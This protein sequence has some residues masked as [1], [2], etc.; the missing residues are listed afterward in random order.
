M[1]TKTD[2]QSESSSR[3]PLCVPER[4]HSPSPGK[5]NMYSYY[6][7]SSSSFGGTPYRVGYPDNYGSDSWRPERSY[8]DRAPPPEHFGPPYLRNT[9]TENWNRPVSYSASF[10]WPD[11]RDSRSSMH[12]DLWPRVHRD[13]MAQR[14]FE[15]SENWKQSH[16]QTADFSGGGTHFH[17][18]FA[19]PS[20][21]NM[22]PP[23]HYRPSSPSLDYKDRYP[24]MNPRSDSYR[25]QYEDDRGPW[26]LHSTEPYRNRYDG[27]VG[28]VRTRHISHSM[29]PPSPEV[30]RE[31]RYDSHER[32]ASASSRAGLLASPHPQIPTQDESRSPRSLP[33]FHPSP[34]RESFEFGLPPTS[35]GASPVSR[36]VSRSSS[37]S[38]HS[39]RQPLR[40]VAKND[41]PTSRS[42]YAD[43]L[44]STPHEDTDIPG[45]IITAPIPIDTEQETDL[46]GTPPGLRIGLPSVEDMNNRETGTL[47]V[48]VDSGQSEFFAEGSP[49]IEAVSSNSKKGGMAIHEYNLTAETSDTP[50]DGSDMEMSL[51]PSPVVE[52]RLATTVKADAALKRF[53]QP[54][55]TF[56]RQDYCPRS[57]NFDPRLS[58]TDHSD[59]EMSPP[60]SPSRSGTKNA[61]EVPTSPERLNSP[62]QQPTSQVDGIPSAIILE[63]T[64]SAEEPHAG[65]RDIS[66]S[67]LLVEEEVVSHQDGFGTDDSDMDMSP[68]A[69][70]VPFA[71]DEKELT[72]AENGLARIL[73]IGA[74]S[75]L[76]PIRSPYHASGREPLDM[77]MADES[78]SSIRLSNA[79][80]AETELI[81][82]LAATVEHPL[83]TVSP[84]QSLQTCAP[85]PRSADTSAFPRAGH[86]S[87]QIDRASNH[88]M[89]GDSATIGHD[90]HD[91]G[92]SG[93][94]VDSVNNRP[95]NTMTTSKVRDK[96]PLSEPLRLVVMTRLRYDRQTKEERVNPVLFANLAIAEPPSL[97]S[98]LSADAVVNG[99]FGSERSPFRV[100]TLDRAKPTLQIRFAQRKA[101]LAEKIQ[102]LR[103]EYLA[104][105][106]RW[107]H[108]CS[109]LD[110]VAKAHALEEAAATAGRTTRRSAALGDAVRSDLEME[111]II[112]SLGNE[113]LTD[114]NHLA[115]RNAA[116]IPDMVSLTNGP[117]EFMFDDT[118]NLVDDPISFYAPRTGT[119]DWTEEEKAVYLERFAVYPKQFGIIAELLPNKSA[120]QC[121][122][123]Y[124]LHKKTDIDFRK[125][126][127]LYATGKRMR[128][129]RKTAKKKGNA[130][131]TDIRKHDAEVSRD[132]TS[133]GTSTRRKRGV[134]TTSTEPRRS[135]TSRRSTTRLET[136]PITTPTP[137]PEPESRRRRRAPKL[138]ARAIAAMEQEGDDEPTDDTPKP[139]KRGR[140]SRKVIKSAETVTSPI[141]M[142]ECIAVF[143][144]TKF[145]DQTE[146]SSRKKSATGNVNWSEEDKELFL[147]L[148][149]QHG[150]DF[151]RIAASMPN[152][153]TIQVSIF[154]KANLEEMDLAKVA[155]SAPKRSPTPETAQDIWKET[156]LPGSGVITPRTKSSTPPDGAPVPVPGLG[157]ET[158]LRSN[159]RSSRSRR[160][161][162]Q[163]LYTSS[164]R[165]QRQTSVT[166]EPSTSTISS[167]GGIQFRQTSVEAMRAQY[168]TSQDLPSRL[169]SQ[170]Q[171]RSS[172]FM[173]TLLPQINSSASSMGDVP[174]SSVF[175]PPSTMPATLTTTFPSTFAYSN[176]SPSHFAGDHRPPQRLTTIQR[177]AS[178]SG[179]APS[180]TMTFD[181]S[182]FTQ[183]PW[184]HTTHL[185]GQ[186]T[187][188]TPGL[189]TT[190]QTTEDLRAYLEHRTRLAGQL[191][192]DFIDF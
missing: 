94:E 62:Q 72:P 112:A 123:Y 177:G 57:D 167:T 21:R 173:G 42:V 91:V 100:D 156:N 153:T 56:P 82:D 54:P 92:P 18:R 29:Q 166:P 165:E 133:K 34:L 155:A 90:Q 119:D 158:H 106:E 63:K 157:V 68:P 84:P 20:V 65:H 11:S 138:T 49:H 152:K 10:A 71:L 33:Y 31:R 9:Q 110:E 22:N 122:T 89:G 93:A 24:Y 144:E 52:S 39:H 98:S 46:A 74:S 69:S 146:L 12:D 76:S 178:P 61:S 192:S 176:L 1:F 163:E 130:L 2:Y 128:G 37:R 140:R 35:R 118:N 148:L 88:S 4:R 26:N 19:E 132:S 136:S 43:S 125:V 8:H 184:S 187:D 83:Q 55:F 86:D 169:Y 40:D 108:H 120:A 191:P 149:A 77:V 45:L 96:H 3:P 117:V 16:G 60:P 36:I 64:G 80:P 104:L 189:P 180:S 107:M 113:E 79:L 121:V 174:G 103:E 151:K 124:Y 116:K 5:S 99:V 171:P 13:T 70:P 129:N 139:A 147:K 105:H 38:S 142:D 175:T 95:P 78:T 134:Q 126:V 131:L 14:M 17:D 143:N 127:S 181:A 145:I 159:E 25:P 109:K 168:K 87:E 111:Q 150:D 53:D 51:P 179:S 41:S 73:D 81:G 115:A 30:L 186:I 164:E 101:A 170:V 154:Y 28:P 27:P 85:V 172:Q 188:T 182:M 162:M 137:D 102:R 59:M 50:Q 15:P 32:S 97:Q 47:E 75:P 6:D 141:I 23:D 160:L 161:Q 183:Q 58:V 135:V 44:A 48:H 66:A 114:A 185:N 67:N 190:L 7:R